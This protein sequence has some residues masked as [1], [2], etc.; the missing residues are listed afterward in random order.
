MV[1]L[2]ALYFSLKT[3]V[4]VRSIAPYCR[5]LILDPLGRLDKREIYTHLCGS[6]CYSAKSRSSAR[7]CCCQSSIYPF[8]AQFR[9]AGF[10][11]RRV[12]QKHRHS[13]RQQNRSLRSIRDI[14]DYL[15]LEK[16]FLEQ[17]LAFFQC[18]FHLWKHL[19]Y[20]T[21]FLHNS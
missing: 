4:F 17:G 20:A 3:H 9:N 11:E 14:P 13:N 18:P 5:G 16:V 2:G 21:P 15:S 8:I 19:L 1:V 6:Q 10:R 12:R 7:K